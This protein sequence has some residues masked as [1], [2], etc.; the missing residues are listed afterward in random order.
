MVVL[1]GAGGLALQEIQLAGKRAMP[2][3]AFARGR[4]EFIGSIL[5]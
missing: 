4:P 5:G 2:P 1:A 3:E